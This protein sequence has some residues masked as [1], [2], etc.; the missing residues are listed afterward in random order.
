MTKAKKAAGKAAAGAPRSPYKIIK[1]RSGRWSVLDRGTRKYINGAEK[2]K[3][4]VAKG[5]VKVK[6]PEAKPAEG[7]APAEA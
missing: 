4:L 6:L 5:L 2:L 1:K 7:T 3:V